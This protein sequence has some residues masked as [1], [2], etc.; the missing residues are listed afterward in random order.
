MILVDTSAWIEFLR[1]T[2]SSACEAV[3]RRIA[4]DLAICDPVSMEV[5]AGACN[6]HH[7]T[8]LRGLLGRATM[9]PTTSNELSVTGCC[10]QSRSDISL[11]KKAQVDN[12][13]RH[14][15]TQPGTTGETARNPKVVGSISTPATTKALVD[16]NICQGILASRPVHLT[17]P[18]SVTFSPGPS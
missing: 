1:D 3:D 6:E 8:Q 13:N 14:K 17:V 10:P 18:P 4:D 2:G 16:G 7:L 11:S 12:T 9:L 15:L 5:L